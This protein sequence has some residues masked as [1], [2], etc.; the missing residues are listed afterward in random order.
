MSAYADTCVCEA[1]VDTIAESCPSDSASFGVRMR[2]C[3]PW[4]MWHSQWTGALTGKKNC[5]RTAPFCLLGRNT[6]LADE[7]KVF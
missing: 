5:W 7:G 2:L 1:V 6:S 3:L 4:E